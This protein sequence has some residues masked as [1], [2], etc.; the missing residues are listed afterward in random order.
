MSTET[1]TVLDYW[2]EIEDAQHLAD[3]YQHPMYVVR[4][5][6]GPVRVKMPH[7]LEGSGEA[8]HVAIPRYRT[9]DD[10]KE[11]NRR[12]GHCWFEP[13]TMRFFSSRVQSTIYPTADGRAYFVSSERNTHR[14]VTEGRRLY[15]VRIAQPDGEIDTVGEF[16]QYRTGRAA[17]AAARRLAEGG[18]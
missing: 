4:E 2:Q 11:R 13:A 9:L 17:H 1:E 5:F 14:S 12:L 8:L 10:I 7:Q 18:E 3:A 6:R 15:T 16:Q